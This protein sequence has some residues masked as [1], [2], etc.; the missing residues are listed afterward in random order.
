MFLLGHRSCRILCG[1]ELRLPASSRE[2]CTRLPIRLNASHFQHILDDVSTTERAYHG[3][4]MSNFSPSRRGKALE[5]VIRSYLTKMSPAQKLQDVERGFRSNGSQL[6]QY[7]SDFDWWCDGKRVECKSAQICWAPS[8]KRWQASFH[9]VKLALAGVRSAAPFDELLLVLYSPFKLHIIR[10]DLSLGVHSAGKR[11][12]SRGNTISVCGGR[13]ETNLH[14]ALATI[15]D[16]FLSGNN[17][18]ELVAELDTRCSEVTKTLAENSTS[19]G[20]SFME[21]VYKG[22]PLSLVQGARRGYIMERLCLEIESSINSA[23]TVVRSC[24][25]HTCDWVRD[26]LRIELK[27]AQLR[28]CEAKQSWLC[29]FQG[30]KIQQ[31][32]KSRCAKFDELWLLIY[33]SEGICIF[34]HQ[35]MFGISWDRQ[36]EI[37]GHSIYVYSQRCV[38][39]VSLALDIIC[40]KLLRG[41]CAQLACIEW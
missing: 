9:G 21:R 24:A 16:K 41:G 37:F 35:D 34:R 13:N 29:H 8:K 27:H 28:W 11:T 14:D 3:D 18:C 25:N 26:G 38:R 23:S 32:G 6:S 5:S 40:A 17:D 2:A 12:A 4:P 20:L 10:H 19:K 36:G 31:P 15:L 30:V 33:S 1:P 7:G 39:D 22:V